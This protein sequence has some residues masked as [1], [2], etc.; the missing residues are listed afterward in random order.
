LNKEESYEEF[1]VLEDTLFFGEEVLILK[2]DEKVYFKKY[3]KSELENLID[4]AYRD[5]KGDREVYD[6]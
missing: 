3:T 2:K 4:E 1:I 6:L 5:L